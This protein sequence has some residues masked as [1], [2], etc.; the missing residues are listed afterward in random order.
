M[1]LPSPQPHSAPLGHFFPLI[2][3]KKSVKLILF[4]PRH[5]IDATNQGNWWCICVCV[6]VYTT[7]HNFM[8]FF[9]HMSVLLQLHYAWYT[10]IISLCEII[11]SMQLREIVL[12]FVRFHDRF[13]VCWYCTY[14]A[15]I[16]FFLVKSTFRFKLRL[17][18][19]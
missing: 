8:C 16:D 13:S 10:I 4:A 7:V 11:Y 2:T 15:F 19:A 18:F 17:Y 1:R 9:L 12:R 14:N 5:L 3:H 6:Q